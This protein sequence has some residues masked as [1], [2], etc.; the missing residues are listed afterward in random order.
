MET[1]WE[2]INKLAETAVEHGCNFR[3]D[4]KSDGDMN[5]CIT[6]N[7]KELD[8]PLTI[9]N[10]FPYPNPQVTWVGKDLTEITY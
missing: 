10:S 8:S 7:N 3:L 2:Q 1:N 4:I 6:Y 5:V 9:P